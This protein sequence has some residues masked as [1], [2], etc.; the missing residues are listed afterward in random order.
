MITDDYIFDNIN[1]IYLTKNDFI[2]KDINN[3]YQLCNDATVKISYV[4]LPEEERDT[5]NNDINNVNSYY[6]SSSPTI[7][8]K[9]AY[10]LFNK[11]NN[12]LIEW[13]E[14]YLNEGSV[15]TTEYPYILFNDN[16]IVGDWILIRFDRK[17]TFKEIEI[18][19]DDDISKI[20]I[21]NIYATN[22]DII[23]DITEGNIINVIHQLNLGANQKKKNIH[24]LISSTTDS[25]NTFVILFS[26]LEEDQK[27]LKL[28]NIKIKANY[29]NWEENIITEETTTISN[30]NENLVSIINTL[31]SNL[32]ILT[33]RFD[34][35]HL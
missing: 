1:L 25:F 26:R 28:K 23:S 7:G 12:E 9:L 6:I 2:I 27:S 32:N 18:Y 29:K 8:D 5:Y 15:K 10:N 14:N 24:R 31:T 4:N 22:N 21:I 35:H 13:P 33:Q 17:I 34:Q 3:N 19:T 11:N 16:Q 30:E 20:E